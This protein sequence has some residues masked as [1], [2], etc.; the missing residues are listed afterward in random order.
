SGRSV[1]LPD[2]YRSTTAYFHRPPGGH[3]KEP[4]ESAGVR[5][6]PPPVAGASTGPRA[7]WLMALSSFDLVH[8]GNS[9]GTPSAGQCQSQ[10]LVIFA[11]IRI[12]LTQFFHHSVG[13]QHRYVTP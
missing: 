4:A 13:L 7:G 11:G 12:T 3:W 10:V 8:V 2:P 6:H 9:L 5:R 1:P